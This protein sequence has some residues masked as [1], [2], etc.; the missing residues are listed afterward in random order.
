M[1]ALLP[2]AIIMGIFIGMGGTYMYFKINKKKDVK[3]LESAIEDTDSHY[4][5][6]LKSEEVKPKVIDTKKVGEV[7]QDKKEDSL[8]DP[9]STSKSE[10]VIEKEVIQNEGE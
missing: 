6:T 8:T 1:T 10:E 5:H 4:N 3:K 2:L 9:A 7:Q